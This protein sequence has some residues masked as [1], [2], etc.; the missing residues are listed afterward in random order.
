MAKIKDNDF[1]SA[2]RDWR[3][4]IANELNGAKQWEEDWGFLTS[5]NALI[6]DNIE[7]KIKKLEAV[8][9]M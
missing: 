3:S 6:N 1:V 9:L 5:E 7:D 8:S 4:L 2:D